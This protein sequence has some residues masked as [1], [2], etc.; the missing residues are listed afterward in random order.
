V[1]ETKQDG[2]S[3]LSYPQV[4]WS[5]AKRDFSRPTPSESKVIDFRFKKQVNCLMADGGA[6]GYRQKDKNDIEEPN[7]TGEN[8]DSLRR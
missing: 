6:R 8:Y 1:V 2:T 5:E 4:T 3:N 7:W